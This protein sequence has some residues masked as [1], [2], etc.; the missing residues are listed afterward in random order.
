MNEYWSNLWDAFSGN[1]QSANSGIVP[2]TPGMQGQSIEANS[3][4]NPLNQLSGQ[5]SGLQMGN[6][7]LG[8][9]TSLLNG[10]LGFQ[11]LSLAKKQFNAA[12][13]QWNTQWQANRKLTNSSLAD[14][15]SARVASNPNAYQSVDSYM[16]KYGI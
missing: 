8:G 15:Q 1:S 10:Y 7:A 16:E 11:N 13:D 14:R 3:V 6:L 4:N 12:Q 5:M 9:V 2:S